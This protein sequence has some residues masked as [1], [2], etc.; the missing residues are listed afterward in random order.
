MKIDLRP[1][2]LNYVA[3]DENGN[4]RPVLTKALT[5]AWAAR[6]KEEG[7][8]RVQIET[9][10]SPDLIEQIETI[11]SPDLRQEHTRRI[12]KLRDQGIRDALI[13]LGWTPPADVVGAAAREKQA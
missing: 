5:D 3:L 4:L 2:A 7:R 12:I 9:R 1:G 6:D 13:A 10:Y 11:L 8:M